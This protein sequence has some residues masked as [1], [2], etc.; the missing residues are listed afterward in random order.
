M[1]VLS[2]FLAKIYDWVTSLSKVSSCRL[3]ISYKSGSIID[4]FEW[5]PK[6]FLHL[7]IKRTLHSYFCTK[8]NLVEI[9]KVALLEICLTIC[10]SVLRCFTS[11]FRF[12]FCGG[13]PFAS[14]WNLIISVRI[15]HVV[16]KLKSLVIISFST[17]QLFKYLHTACFSTLTHFTP[18][19]HFYTL[20]KG[21]KTYGFLMTFS[22]DI[23]MWHWTKMG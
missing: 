21:Q 10:S 22:G 8:Y 15:F 16:E 23:E 3:W 12:C 14:L 20:W 9:V 18:M 1:R 6:I 4:V 11:F 2:N 19:L 5:L 7:Y 13:F 17:D